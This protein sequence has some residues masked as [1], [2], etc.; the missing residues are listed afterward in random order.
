M[1]QTQGANSGS[2]SASSSQRGCKK[3]IRKGMKDENRWGM[4]SVPK[5]QKTQQPEPRREMIWSGEEHTA[6]L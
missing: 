5:R 6:R 2:S 3:A 4:G 1:S